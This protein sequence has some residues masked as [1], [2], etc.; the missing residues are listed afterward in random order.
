M[1]PTRMS[2]NGIFYVPDGGDEDYFEAEEFFRLNRED[3]TTMALGVGQGNLPSYDYLAAIENYRKAFAAEPNH[4]RPAPQEESS[5]RPED[6]TVLELANL[7]RET[8]KQLEKKT[9]EIATLKQQLS[10]EKTKNRSHKSKQDDEFSEINVLRIKKSSE[11]RE[12]DQNLELDSQRGKII[13]D[14]RAGVL[15]IKDQM[16]D[17]ESEN[18]IQTIETTPQTDDDNTMKVKDRSEDEEKSYIANTGNFIT[19]EKVNSL[20]EHSGNDNIQAGDF[21]QGEVEEDKENTF[22]N[23]QMAN[24]TEKNERSRLV[25]QGSLVSIVSLGIGVRNSVHEEGCMHFW[26]E[27]RKKLTSD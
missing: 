4:I 14:T 17:C 18:E 20:T 15:I 25:S 26:K 16:L 1:T 9:R 23:I 12:R 21:L 7:L 13:N 6:V 22:E 24:K 5:T 2:C 3:E 11:M 19:N 27:V 10:E 8:Q